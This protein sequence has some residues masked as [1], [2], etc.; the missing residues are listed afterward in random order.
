MWMSTAEL[1]SKRWSKRGNDP[2]STGTSGS[3]VKWSFLKTEDLQVTIGFNTKSWSSMIIH[4]DW[5]IWCYPHD[6]GNGTF[7]ISRA[8][9]N[10]FGFFGKIKRWRLDETPNSGVKNNLSFFKWMDMNGFVWKDAATARVPPESVGQSSKSFRSITCSTV[11][12]VS[13]ILRQPQLYPTTD[14]CGNNEILAAWPVAL[15][16][17]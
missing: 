10:L 15:A 6:L 14:W 17:T 11:S 1:Q 3:A 2:Q 7:D 8:F 9:G 16:M 4:D 5:M 13:S 12:T